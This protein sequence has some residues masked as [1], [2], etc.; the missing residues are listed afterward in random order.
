MEFTY[1]IATQKNIKIISLTGKLISEVN[2]ASLN[3][4]A[5]NLIESN[6]NQ[7]IINLE[8]LKFLNS[9]GINFF[10]RTLTKARVSNGD[11]VFTGVNGMVSEL[12]SMA[13]LTKIYTIY[14]SLEE[15]I[16]HFN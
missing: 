3:E 10:M 8:G 12:F 7:L 13:K 16:N 5:S 14:D 2:V 1:N 6:H 15:A 4:E 9:S 11:L